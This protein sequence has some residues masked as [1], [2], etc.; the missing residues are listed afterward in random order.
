MKNAQF[1]NGGVSL[2]RQQSAMSYELSAM[3]YELRAISQLGAVVG[4]RILGPLTSI[5]ILYEL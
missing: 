2:S 3:S 5:S 4:F 1:K